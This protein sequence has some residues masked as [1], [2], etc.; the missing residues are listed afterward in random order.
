MNA[1]EARELTF[2]NSKSPKNWQLLDHFLARIKKSASCGIREV[3]NPVDDYEGS[4]KNSLEVCDCLK[5][6]GYDVTRDDKNGWHTVQYKI[7]W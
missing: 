3:V 5:S 2:R 4:I 6:M 7:S 1:N